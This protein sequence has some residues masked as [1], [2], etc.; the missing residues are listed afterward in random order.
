M[1]FCSS[2]YVSPRFRYPAIP[3]GL[4]ISWSRCVRLQFPRRWDIPQ[5]T[6][7][8]IP[9]SGHTVLFGDNSAAYTVFLLET[10]Q[11]LL[12]GVDLYHWFASGFGHMDNLANPRMSPFD[13]PIIGSVV[14]LTVQ[15]FFAYRL[16]VLSDKKSWWLCM[17]I[18]VV[19]QSHDF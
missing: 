9:S 11:T 8:V 15:L 19:S 18:C 14:S 1:G 5:A 7:H 2:S 16:W 17:A 3:F 13:G 10:V 12:T 6:G 4:L